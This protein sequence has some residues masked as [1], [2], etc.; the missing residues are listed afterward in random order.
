M[1]IVN[2]NNELYLVTKITDIYFNLFCPCHEM[3]N[4]IKDIDFEKKKRVKKN[5]L[6]MHTGNKMVVIVC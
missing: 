6:R 5:F 2:D 1:S 4:M 3:P